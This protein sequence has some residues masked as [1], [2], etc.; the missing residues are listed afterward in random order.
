MADEWRASSCPDPGAE[1]LDER[2]V[3]ELHSLA[4]LA[5]MAVFTVLEGRPRP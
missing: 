4:M 2:R 5:G 1:K 3:T